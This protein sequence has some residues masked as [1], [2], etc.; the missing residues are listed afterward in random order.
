MFLINLKYVTVTW[1]FKMATSKLAQFTATHVS[2]LKSN[3]YG[4]LSN[5]KLDSNVSTKVSADLV[6]MTRTFSL[7]IR[8]ITGFF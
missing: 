2:D 5:V 8:V 1:L 6:Q 3:S 4:N 7:K